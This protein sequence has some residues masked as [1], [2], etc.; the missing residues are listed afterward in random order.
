MN[1]KLKRIGTDFAG[2]LLIALGIA[3]G[4]LPG[5]GGVPLIL[6]GLGLLSIHNKWARQWRE[7]LIGHAGQFTKYIFPKHRVIQDGYDLLALILLVVV[8]A[9]A[10]LH[11]AVWQLSL[12]IALFFM[13]ILI[14]GF[15]RDRAASLARKVSRKPAKPAQ[16]ADVTEEQPATG[17]AT[18]RTT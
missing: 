1:L 17:S 11:V 4:W 2:Y 10:W 8:V 18:R 6:A 5:P 13:A 3:F 9:L 15:N 12:A 14:V 7:W 16:P